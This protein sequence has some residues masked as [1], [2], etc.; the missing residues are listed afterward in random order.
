MTHILPTS[1]SHELRAGGRKSSPTKKGGAMY[2]EVQNLTTMGQ[3]QI[4]TYCIHLT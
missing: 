1:S 4:L 2:K 3:G